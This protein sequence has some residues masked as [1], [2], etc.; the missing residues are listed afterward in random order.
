M[1]YDSQIYII[2]GAVSLL[3]VIATA[4]AGLCF[5]KRKRK[6]YIIC[7]KDQ[8]RLPSF[9][10]NFIIEESDSQDRNPRI[11]SRQNSSTTFLASEPR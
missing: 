5:H 4:S 7:D 6:E 8:N 10:P 9:V 3:G 2:L 11:I 1:D